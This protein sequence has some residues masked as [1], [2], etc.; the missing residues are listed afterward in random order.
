MTPTEEI[1]TPLRSNPG[2]KGTG[3]RKE[4][5]P[6]RGTTRSSQEQARSS[7]VNPASGA[8]LMAVCPLQTTTLPPSSLGALRVRLIEQQEPCLS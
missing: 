7:D 6:T 3:F 4:R 5:Q 2:L 8:L 1:I